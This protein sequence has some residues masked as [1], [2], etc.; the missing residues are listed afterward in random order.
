MPP[1]ESIDVEQMSAAQRRALEA[2]LLLQVSRR[3]RDADGIARREP[4]AE[5]PLA[6]TQRRLWFLHELNRGQ[7]RGEPRVDALRFAYLTKDFAVSQARQLESAAWRA[8]SESIE[9]EIPADLVEAAQAVGLKRGATLFMTMLAV[10]LLLMQ[11]YSGDDTVVCGVPASGRNLRKLQDAMGFF[12]NALSIRVD[13]GETVSDAVGADRDVRQNPVLPSELFDI[14]TI[15]RIRDHHVAMLRA[16][17][18]RPEKSARS[19]RFLGASERSELVLGGEGQGS[20]RADD[21]E[22]AVADWR[23]VAGAGLTVNFVDADH[24]SIVAPPRGTEVA[25]T[26]TDWTAKGRD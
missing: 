9:V 19:L 8:E 23:H 10:Y 5:I 4:G 16:A 20:A 6:P 17:A 15:A 14:D 1:K 24:Y 2:V 3:R 13:V 12:V 11:R 25:A 26:V 7:L 18:A 22:Q 21:R